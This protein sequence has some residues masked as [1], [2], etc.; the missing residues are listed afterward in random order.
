VFDQLC[1]E[2]FDRSL[3]ACKLA[4]DRAGLEPSDVTQ[5]VITG[6]VSR[7]PM[8]RSGLSRWFEREVTTLVSPE[9]AIALGAGLKA[10]AAIEYPVRGVAKRVT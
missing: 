3:A 2:L 8:V 9:E 1:Q 10:A 6:G 4:L 7:I 5:L